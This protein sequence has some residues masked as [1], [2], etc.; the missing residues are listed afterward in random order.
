MV[1]KKYKDRLFCMLFGSEEYKE[2]ILSLYNALRGTEHEDVDDIVIY[3][4]D[5]VIYIG[6]K[7]DVSVMLDSYLSLWEQQSTFNPNMP[8]RG[9]MYFGKM[10]DRY[11]TENKLNIYGKKLIPIPTPTYTVFYNGAAEQPSCVKLRL[12]NSFMHPDE[13]G[14]FEW[15]ATMINLNEGKNDALLKSCRPLQE[16]MILIGLIRKCSETMELEEA[17]DVAV[18]Q[19]IE[20]GVLKEFLLKH[21]AEVKEM[22]LTEFDEQA[23]VEGIREEGYEEGSYK[24]A[25]KIYQKQGKSKEEIIQILMDEFEIDED[26]AIEKC[27][28]YAPDLFT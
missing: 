28:Q 6:M 24:T 19:C 25:I 2:N 5:D 1:N 16:Y 21:K 22:C 14:E 23:F 12:T 7:N 13:S 27:S 11:I 17:V 4:I 15:T 3:T 9:M 8:L 18:E 10:Y 20:R 26:T